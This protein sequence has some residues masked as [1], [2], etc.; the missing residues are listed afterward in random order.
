MKIIYR[1]E[2]DGLRALAV[3]SVI[4]YHSNISFFDRH[5]FKG[6]YLGVDI[7]FVISG[8]LITLLILKE[9]YLTGNFSFKY[10]YERRIRRIIPTLLIVI[11]MSIPFSFIFLLPEDLLNYTESIISSLAFVSNFYFYF[12]GQEYDTIDALHKP[13][14]HTWSLSVE[15]QFYILFP[16]LLFWLFKKFKSYLLTILL[17]IFLFSLQIADW[18]TSN[19]PILNF[20]ILPTRVWELM[21]GSL[22]AYYE[23]QLGH[24]NKIKSLN[25]IFPSIGMFLIANSIVFFNHDTPYP[26]FYSLIP[27]L[28]TCMLIWFSSK[29]ELITKILSSKLFV[30][31]GLISYSLYLWHYPI[32]AFA[33][34]NFDNLTNTIILLSLIIIIFLSI[35]TF[36]FIEKIFRNKNLEFNKVLVFIIVSTILIFSYFFI[37]LFKDGKLNS[38]NTSIELTKNSPIYNSEC[39]YSTSVKDYKTD[40]YFKNQFD[41][42]ID[43]HKKFILVLG[44]SHSIDLFNIL[45]KYSSDDEFIVGFNKGGCRPNSKVSTKCHYLNSLKFIENYKKSI[46]HI[47]YNQKGSYFLTNIGNS[48]QAGLSEFRELPIN[49]IEIENSINYLKLIHKITNNVTFVGP[50]AEPNVE[51]NRKNIINYYKNNISFVD[52]TNNYL[53]EVDKKLEEVSKKNKLNYISQIKIINFNFEEDFIVESK[54]TYSDTDHFSSFG[55]YYFGKKLILNSIIKSILKN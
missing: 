51:L 25:L 21:A 46:K 17:I 18:G 30:G 42:C 7:F 50:H 11:L 39:K 36:F 45:S 6:G 34:I 3:L 48:N 53:N 16:I 12:S 55:E 49:I 43:K 40:D 22:L 1:P 31:F 4:F 24:R 9:L 26:S 20:Y 29:D 38:I 5:P 27:V 8:Y 14:L 32:F 23:L 47:F 52:S 28:G 13:F 33:R 41:K 15:E 54:I 37:V 35:L 10:F 19:F 2:I 44:D